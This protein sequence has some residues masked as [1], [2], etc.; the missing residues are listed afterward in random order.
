MSNN[1]KGQK[2][3]AEIRGGSTLTYTS[4]PLPKPMPQKPGKNK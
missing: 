4:R 1:T 3:S 2:V